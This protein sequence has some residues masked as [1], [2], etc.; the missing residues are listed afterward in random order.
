MASATA[1]KTRPI[2]FNH[3]SG[4]YIHTVLYRFGVGL[5]RKVNRHEESSNGA[6]LKEHAAS[7]HNDGLT[8]ETHYHSGL[9]QIS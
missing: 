1:C 2:R 6:L 7:S 3:R 4:S 9:Y 5:I 8:N